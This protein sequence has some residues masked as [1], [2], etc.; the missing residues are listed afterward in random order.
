MSAQAHYLC[1]PGASWGR[2]LPGLTSCSKFSY[3]RRRGAAAQSGRLPLSV[4]HAAYRVGTNDFV[5]FSGNHGGRHAAR[6]RVDAPEDGLVRGRQL[7]RADRHPRHGLPAGKLRRCA[8]GRER[9]SR[10]GLVAF[11]SASLLPSASHRTVGYDPVGR[12]R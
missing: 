9:A 10:S 2:A 11:G 6:P 1:L 3:G 12:V 7:E 8:E 4:S 5:I